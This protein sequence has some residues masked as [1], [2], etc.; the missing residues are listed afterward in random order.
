MAFIYFDRLTSFFSCE[1]QMEYHQKKNMQSLSKIQTKLQTARSEYKKKCVITKIE[2]RKLNR[3]SWDRYVSNF[4][5]DVHGAQTMAYK[6][7]F[8]F[9]Q[10]Y[11]TWL[12][13]YKICGQTLQRKL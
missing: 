4:E 2:V 6:I 10:Y 3:E 9:N 5:Y 8:I 11:I 1:L 7:E 12:N 13:Y